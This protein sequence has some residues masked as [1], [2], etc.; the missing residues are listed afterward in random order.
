MK[1]ISLAPSTTNLLEEI[2]CEDKLKAVSTLNNSEKY[3]NAGGWVSGP[4]MNVIREIDPDI[5]ITCDRLQR[6]VK[7]KIEEEGFETAHYEP[8]TLE[9]VYQHILDLGKLVDAEERSQETVREMKTCFDSIDL[10][11]ARIY[12][13]EWS[14]PPMASGNWVPGL[15]RELNGKYILDSGR[16]REV[17]VSEMKDFDPEAISLN[18]CGKEATLPREIKERE[19]YQNISAVK[20]NKISVI[21]DSLLNQPNHKL[22][23]GAKSLV[24][25]LDDEK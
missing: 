3:K 21:D 14:D 2:G 7:N 25:L 6:E 24:R 12:C 8:E 13:E 15:I 20:N 19:G 16:S 10:K 22:I 5:V 18:I 17:S 11:G 1:I 23:D 4:K 9:Q